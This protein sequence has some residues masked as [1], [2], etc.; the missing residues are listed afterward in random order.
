[1]SSSVFSGEYALSVYWRQQ[2]NPNEFESFVLH[3]KNSEQY[4]QWEAAITKLMAADQKRREMRDIDRHSSLGANRRHI[5]SATNFAATPASDGPSTGPLSGGYFE[6]DTVMAGWDDDGGTPS[7]SASSTP[8]LSRRTLSQSGMARPP[9]RYSNLSAR[10]SNDDPNGLLMAQW[11][12]QQNATPMPPIPM[13]N[14]SDASIVT[15][16]SFGNPSSL[17][18]SSL[19]RGGL[20]TRIARV[21][22]DDSH[23]PALATTPETSEAGQEIL[24]SN[25]ADTPN[26]RYT[27]GG[28]GGRS[29]NGFY[30][31]PSQTPSLRMRSASSPNVYQLPKI[32]SDASNP[33]TSPMHSAS[34][35]GVYDARNNVTA[36][37]YGDPGAHYVSD[38]HQGSDPRF[39][40][41]KASNRGSGSTEGSDA[42][43]HSPKTPFDG[44]VPD[45]AKIASGHFTGS[46]TDMSQ[47]YKQNVIIKVLSPNVSAPTSTVSHR[48]SPHLNLLFR[49]SS[50]SLSPRTSAAKI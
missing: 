1:M 40:S 6:R 13:R 28:I 46:S 33:Q 50:Q 9:D 41:P 49:P 32:G 19:G 37:D 11:R 29:S 25:G 42:S 12:S 39:K 30:P 5:S 45:S 23:G 24:R 31:P 16:A 22:S 20:P 17:P 26:S 7:T 27:N 21:M 15:E 44:Q 18:R 48:A 38:G 10:S 43:S 47:P 14:S 3:V 8:Y 34:P 2:E 35:L 4:T 36:H